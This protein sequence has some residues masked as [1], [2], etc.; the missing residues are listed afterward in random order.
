MTKG[1][2]P[3][4]EMAAYPD[5][6]KAKEPRSLDDILSSEAARKQ[7]GE[8]TVPA[9]EEAAQ[10]DSV[11]AAA[12]RESDLHEVTSAMPDMAELL[13][14]E[15]GREFV[16]LSDYPL[17][18][19]RLLKMIPIDVAKQMG[20]FPLQE[21]PDGALLIAISDPL[22]V[23]IEDD[24][25]LRLGRH[26]RTVIA[27]EDAIFDAIDRYYG[28]GELTLESLLAEDGEESGDEDVLDSDMSQHDLGTLDEIVNQP[29]VVR[30][31]NLVLMQTVRHRASDLHAEPFEGF[32][33]IRYRV[34]GVLREMPSPPQNLQLGIISRLKV[35]AQMD[36]AIT[37]KPQDGRIKLNVDGREVDMR[38]SSLPTV[39]GESIVMRVLDRSMMMVGISQ[40]GMTQE[41]LD[42]FLK[43]CTRPNGILLVTGPTGCGKTTT[44]Y[45]ALTEI[46]DPGDKVITT[47]EPVE[48]D[49]EGIIQINI[50]E[51]VGLTFARCLRAILRQDPDKIL[52]G[53]IR[54]LETAEIAVQ[55]A[56][57]GH[58]VLST[59]HTNSAAA[60]I[61]RLIDMGVEPFL[62][63]STMQAIVGQ[64]LVRTICPNCKEPY[65]PLPEELAEFGVAAEDVGDIT[66]YHGT[67]CP[68]CANTGYKGRMGIFE[69]LETDDE[70]N[71]L[72]LER[73]TMDLIHA[74]A[75]KKG[76]ATM[77]QDGW[78]KICLGYTTFAEV[79]KQ[80]PSAEEDPSTA[81][82]AAGDAEEPGPDT[83]GAAADD[84]E[85]KET[86]AGDEAAAKV[87][88][89]SPE[90]FGDPGKRAEDQS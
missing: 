2:N 65:E 68:E 89:P 61:T 28:I 86:M 11:K 70:I 41:V 90:E 35:M 39:H 10:L 33:R 56:L 47:E 9:G 79:S 45:A 29:A 46:N 25:R 80:T 76:M 14:K 26:V 60:T 58:L 49:L 62:I 59:L 5:D 7:G 3:N 74:A 67:G 78:I 51:S 20:C 31:V 22:N 57:T 72:I 63:T 38:V 53:E 32:M 64:R 6:G 82:L 21:E 44:L 77:R 17:R 34:D 12:D 52:V 43:I 81:L 24:L 13:A 54:D 40:I 55:A 84:E 1:P 30:M 27:E 16:K 73:V 85:K 15:H 83:A 69:F 48:Y 36:I 23:T 18:D 50:N 8:T 42:R 19:P 37:R 66:F 71:E 87:K 88:G 4:D 75:V